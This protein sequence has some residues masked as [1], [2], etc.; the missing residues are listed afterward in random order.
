MIHLKCLIRYCYSGVGHIKTPE[1][2]IFFVEL[3]VRVRN[4]WS[5]P[6]IYVLGDFFISNVRWLLL[7]DEWQK[8][9]VLIVHTWSSQY[10]WSISCDIWSLFIWILFWIYI[11][12][13]FEYQEYRALFLYSISIQWIEKSK[14]IQQFS[15]SFSYDQHYERCSRPIPRKANSMRLRTEVYEA[16]STIEEESDVY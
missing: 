5:L 7:F 6:H 12:I 3:Y 4:T 13:Y 11:E 16:H 9:G 10:T 15:V 8:I 1:D 14:I 2:R